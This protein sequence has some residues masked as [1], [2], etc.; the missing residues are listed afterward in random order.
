MQQRVNRRKRVKPARNESFRSN[1]RAQLRKDVVY[2]SRTLAPAEFD[3]VVRTHG[4][5]STGSLTATTLYQILTNSILQTGSGWTS[6]NQS[7]AQA[8]VLRNYTA[9]RV[10]K[11]CLKYTI[12][13]RSTVA[14]NDDALIYV[15]HTPDAIALATTSLVAQ[16]D[17]LRDLTHIHALGLATGSP[18]ILSASQTYRL[19][20]VVGSDTYIQDD[21][22]AGGSN[23][24]GV[25][26]A[27]ANLTYV[28]FALGHLAVGGTWAASITAPVVSV[29]LIQY[30]KFYDRRV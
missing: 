23:S 1:F 5:C 17:A 27:P 3:T 24:S 4:V 8:N 30:V 28:T 6:F 14:T 12:I 20:Q 11:Y 19:D 21:G 25:P 26:T 10:M 2:S 22:Y 29:E 7:T 15:I 18:S 9:Y 16:S 13:C